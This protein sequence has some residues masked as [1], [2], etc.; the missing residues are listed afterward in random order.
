MW[1]RGIVCEISHKKFLFTL[2]LHLQWI[3][4]FCVPKFHYPKHSSTLPTHHSTLMLLFSQFFFFS[5]QC[6]IFNKIKLSEENG[7]LNTETAFSVLISLSY[8]NWD[9]ITNLLGF[10]FLEV[11]YS[12]C[13]NSI[14]HLCFSEQMELVW[15]EGK[16][17]KRLWWYT[18]KKNIQNFV[19]LWQPE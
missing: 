14:K 5:S 16:G 2:V 12:I 11:F 7:Y 3:W 10:I 9:R 1:L 15:Q 13:W 6:K 19:P 4:N 18:W 17:K 8:L